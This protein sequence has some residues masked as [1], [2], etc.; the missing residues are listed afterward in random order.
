MKTYMEIREKMSAKKSIN[1]FK[2]YLF[3]LVRNLFVVFIN[4]TKIIKLTKKNL[5]FI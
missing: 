5:K 2:K 4:L 3:I 1:I